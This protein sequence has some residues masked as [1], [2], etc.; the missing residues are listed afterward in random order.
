MMTKLANNQQPH[1]KSLNAK[2]LWKRRPAIAFLGACV[3]MLLHLG[4]PQTVQGQ[5]TDLRTPS[6]IGA[7]SLGDRIYAF[8]SKCFCQFS[9]K[10]LALTESQTPDFLPLQPY[11][12]Q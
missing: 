9:D 2:Y 4:I 7:A 8:A 12:H 10:L 3:F 1:P 11:P 5:V 6:A